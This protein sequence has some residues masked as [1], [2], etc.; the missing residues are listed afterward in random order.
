[1]RVTR[2]SLGGIRAG[3]DFRLSDSSFSLPMSLPVEYPA[4]LMSPSPLT[5]MNR[6]CAIEWKLED[7]IESG[8]VL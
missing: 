4:P 8:S 3:P 2:S 1:M 7:K 5:F 6:S